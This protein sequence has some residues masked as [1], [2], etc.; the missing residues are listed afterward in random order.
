MLTVDTSGRILKIALSVDGRDYYKDID[1]GYK[2]V[3]NLFPFL[4]N[5][6]KRI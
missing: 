3:E 1:E 6:F 5:L 2:H 4:E